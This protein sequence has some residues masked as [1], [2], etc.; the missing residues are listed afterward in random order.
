MTPTKLTPGVPNELILKLINNGN[1][2]TDV[3]VNVEDIPSTWTWWLTSEGETSPYRFRSVY[4]MIY[5]MR[6]TSVCGF[7]CP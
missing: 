6:K 5:N 7:Y 4:P 1:G 3:T 2:A